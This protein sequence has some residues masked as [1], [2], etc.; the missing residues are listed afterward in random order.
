MDRQ[1]KISQFIEEFTNYIGNEYIASKSLTIDLDT[2]FDQLNFDLVDEVITEHML[3]QIFGLDSWKQDAWP[4]SI[5]SLINL[6][7]IDHAK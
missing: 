2:R 6:I 7:K 5:G 4:E 1:A 3:K